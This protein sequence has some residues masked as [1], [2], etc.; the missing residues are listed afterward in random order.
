MDDSKNDFRPGSRAVSIRAY[1]VARLFADCRIRPIAGGSTEVMKQ[2]IGRD[3]F[4]N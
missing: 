4:N 3:L 1:H 2:I